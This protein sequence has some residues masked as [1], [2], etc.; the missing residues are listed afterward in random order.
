MTK[1]VKGKVKGLQA[2]SYSCALEHGCEVKVDDK[3]FFLLKE[4]LR[5][6]KDVMQMLSK[7]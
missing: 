4:S 2:C 7:R 3:F 6:N 5:E 1:C